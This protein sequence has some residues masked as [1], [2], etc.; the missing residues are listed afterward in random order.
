MRHFRFARLQLAD[1]TTQLVSH[2]VK[3]Q[4]QLGDLIASSQRRSRLQVTLSHSLNRQ[5]QSSQGPDHAPGQDRACRADCQN[6]HGEQSGDVA[7]HRIS[8]GEGIGARLEDH[9][10]PVT[11]GR[12][13]E[14]RQRHCTSA[15]RCFECAALPRGQARHRLIAP[16]GWL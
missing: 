9:Q 4:A 16:G 5:L 10:P 3:G 15:V 2:M 13:R 12:G 14:R 8:G 11:A 7:H 1:R 6:A